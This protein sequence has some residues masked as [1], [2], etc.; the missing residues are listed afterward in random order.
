MLPLLFH[1][2]ATAVCKSPVYA[3][4]L[5]MAE[6]PVAVLNTACMLQHVPELLN[7]HCVN[8]FR[9]RG[10]LQE[11]AICGHRNNPSVSADVYVP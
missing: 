4:F 6:K 8:T 1:D 3:S 5:V 7:G 10:D 2:S 9:G 11:W